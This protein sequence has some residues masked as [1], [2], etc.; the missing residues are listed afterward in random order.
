MVGGG[1]YSG[2]KEN[3]Q[4]DMTSNSGQDGGVDRHTLVLCTTKRRTTTNLKTENNQNCQKFR[5]YGSLTTRELEKKHSSPLVGGQRWAAGMGRTHSKDSP[6][7]AF[8]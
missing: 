2:F 1:S 7:F 4:N 8:G 6:I 3:L 5:L